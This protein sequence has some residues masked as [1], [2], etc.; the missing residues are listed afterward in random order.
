M[1]MKTELEELEATAAKL[2]K[3]I[4]ELKK[5]KCEPTLTPV[6]FKSEIELAKALLNGRTFQTP[7]GSTLCLSITIGSSPFRVHYKNG[8]ASAMLHVWELFNDLQEINAEPKEWYHNIPPEGVV[9]HV[10]NKSRHDRGK[11]ARVHTY[12]EGV[13]CLYKG[14]WKEYHIQCSWLY[15]TPVNKVK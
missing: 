3:Q 10:S 2:Q 7:A 14:L 15:A 5:A 8:G 1:I 11:T 13:P 4:Q 9:C 6:S 12:R